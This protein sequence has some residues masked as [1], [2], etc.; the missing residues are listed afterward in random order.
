MKVLKIAAALIMSFSLASAALAH[1]E[2]VGH[3]KGKESNTLAE[4]V[5][6]FNETN[7]QLEALLAGEVTNNDIAAVHEATYTLEK[8]LEK[9]HSELGTLAETL[10]EVHLASEKFNRDGVKTNGDKYIAVVKEL[11]KLGDSK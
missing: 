10:E 1:E 4:A 9:I 3:F 6:N 8:A 7:K 5:A 11:N 2:R